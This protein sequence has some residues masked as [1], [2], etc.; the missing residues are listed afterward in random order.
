ML[1]QTRLPLP[2]VDPLSLPDA[3]PGDSEDEKE[4]RVAG[5]MGACY[6]VLGTLG[7][8]APSVDWDQDPPTEAQKPD[9]LWKGSPHFI[10]WVSSN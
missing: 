7:P 6:A 9:A 1:C 8:A 10:Y 3:S 2:A 5:R 4:T